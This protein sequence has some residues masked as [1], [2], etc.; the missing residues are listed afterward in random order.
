[1]RAH[2][3]AAWPCGVSMRHVHAHD[4]RCGMAAAIGKSAAQV[5]PAHVSCA[6]SW[7]V[8]LAHGCL[9]AICRRPTAAKLR[10]IPG[11]EHRQLDRVL[12]VDVLQFG[13][14]GLARLDET[15]AQ[16]ARSGRRAGGPPGG[17]RAGQHA[18]DVGRR[19]LQHVGNQHDAQRRQIQRPLAAS[20]SAS[21]SA[22]GDELAGPNVLDRLA[23]SS[24]I[25]MA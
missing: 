14:Q 25:G 15:V 12:V 9:R 24:S 6:R 22:A 1:M 7:S 20:C 10:S 19:A 13:R 8:P 3:H 2:G 16:Q 21:G 11:R 18:I 17:R 5:Q 4:M 23:R